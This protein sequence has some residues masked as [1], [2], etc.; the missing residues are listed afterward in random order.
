MA[1]PPD[2]LT[3][4]EGKIDGVDQRLDSVNQRLKW[5]IGGLVVLVPTFVTAS[6]TFTLWVNSYLISHSQ[7]IGQ[8]QGAREVSAAV[9][10]LSNLNSIRPVDAETREHLKAE[11]ETAERTIAQNEE[12]G[13][14]ISANVYHRLGT[15]WCTRGG[16]L[17]EMD[18]VNSGIKAFWKSIDYLQKALEIDPLHDEALYY[19]GFCYEKLAQLAKLTG[20]TEKEQQ[21]AAEAV[22]ALKKSLGLR[23]Q[24]PNAAS[25]HMSLAAALYRLSS[26]QEAYS[27]LTKSLELDPLRELTD[28][29]RS[30][31][32]KFEN[33]G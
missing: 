13:V 3:R 23:P 20:D 25:A 7:A 30:L 5:I 8:L 27:E 15:F 21:H 18:D 19:E 10:K 1:T 12:E 33:E 29:L 22:K 26:L 6:V 9:Q 24:N 11:I 31:K 32:A 16:V 14:L 4:L 28:D 17:V 2:P